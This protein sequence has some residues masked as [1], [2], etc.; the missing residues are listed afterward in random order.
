MTTHDAI[1]RSIIAILIVVG[2]FGLIAVVLFGFVDVESPTIAKLLGLLFG[3][4]SGLLQ[5][6]I[7]RYFNSTVAQ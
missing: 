4:V 1:T 6:I 3:Y 5:P 2:F 7:V